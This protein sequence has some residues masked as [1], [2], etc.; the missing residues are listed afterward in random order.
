MI[1]R[2]NLRTD[3]H[4][5]MRLFKEQI[6]DSPRTITLRAKMQQCVARRHYEKL[7]RQSI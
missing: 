6:P 4:P 2:S 5:K 7:A 1:I 3:E